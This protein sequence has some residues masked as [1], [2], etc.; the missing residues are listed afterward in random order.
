[1]TRVI[2]I[3]FAGTLSISFAAIFIRWGLPAPPVVQ[4]FY[5]VGIGCLLM[6]SW[7][8]FRREPLGLSRRDV[9]LVAGAGFCF[10]ADHAL[11]HTAVVES[12]V[13]NATLL[14]N[15]TPVYIG[16]HAVLWLRER[17]D[18]RFVA[19]AIAALIGAA[20]VLG[21]DLPG[22]SSVEGDV[23]ALI[24]GLFYAGYLLLMKAARSG[25][26]TIP[27]LFCATASATLLL[28]GIVVLRGEP[29]RGFPGSAWAAILA[30]ATLSQV[31]GVV[32]IIWAL[33]YLRATF[34]SVGLLLQPIGTAV[35]GWLLLG[36]AIETGQAVGAGLVLIGIALAARQRS[37]EKERSPA[38]S[39]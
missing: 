38:A 14:V 5:R 18:P 39:R 6:G 21:A 29:L 4:A 19:G 7:L 33:R 28:G 37:D 13:A 34:V 31:V 27:I 1:M 36:E 11:W 32:S 2:T 30:A 20:L 26:S 23:L 35:L 16:L 10:G 22:A 9:L 24:A 3:F 15:L 25:A 17:L 8:L 12:S